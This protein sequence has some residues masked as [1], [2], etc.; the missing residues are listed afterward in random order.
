MCYKR[1]FGE[2]EV[3]QGYLRGKE[4]VL[5]DAC[6]IFWVFKLTAFDSIIILTSVV[7]YLINALETS[8]VFY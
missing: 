2:V 6:T 4:D 3:V 1:S 8:Q 7:R 5:F